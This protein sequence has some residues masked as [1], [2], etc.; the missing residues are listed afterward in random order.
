VISL[1]LEPH[2]TYNF[3]QLLAA[4][5]IAGVFFFALRKELSFIQRLWLVLSMAALARPISEL[6]SLYAAQSQGRSYTGALIAQILGIWIFSFF[7]KFSFEVK[8]KIWNVFALV[9]GIA[10]ALLRVG[11]HFRGCCW[12]KLCPF[13]WAI[14]YNNPSVVT[15][16]L[17]LPLHPVQLY[18]AI[19]GVLMSVVVALYLKKQ[20]RGSAMGVFLF[21]LGAGR[22]F[23]DSFRGDA[24]YYEQSLLG[25][26]PNSVLSSLTMATGL[27][28]LVKANH[29]IQQ[30][31]GA[32][33]PKQG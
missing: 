5:L 26:E 12:G 19:H 18:S 10:Y 11:C 2:T 14:Y 8:T 21:T 9:S 3:F 28:L 20:N 13:E 25:F 32:N 1:G 22:L 7:A 33:L 24:S 6:T 27:F 17:Q 15:P 29:R 16:W 31:K 30:S 4:A 23:T